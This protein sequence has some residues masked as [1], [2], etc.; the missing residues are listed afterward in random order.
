MKPRIYGIL[1]ENASEYTCPF[2]SHPE[3]TGK[4]DGTSCMAWLSLPTS[5]GHGICGL[6]P[7]LSTTPYKIDLEVDY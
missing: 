5:E 2:N 7:I 6:L 3:C 1:A 4:C